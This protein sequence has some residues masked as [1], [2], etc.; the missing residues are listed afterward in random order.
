MATILA[1]SLYVALRGRI[2]GQRAETVK[3]QIVGG[4]EKGEGGIIARR[5]RDEVPRI[6]HKPATSVGA[7]PAEHSKRAGFWRTGHQ[8]EMHPSDRITGSAFALLLLK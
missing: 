2:A 8:A 4:R 6:Q 5:K 7:K 1:I 3:W